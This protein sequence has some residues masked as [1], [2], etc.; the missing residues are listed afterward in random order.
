MTHYFDKKQ[1]SEFKPIK[2][3]ISFQG[4]KITFFSASGI[5]SK[6]ELDTGSALLIRSAIIKNGFSVLDLGCGFGAIGIILAKKYPLCSFTLAD[7]N[8]RAVQISKMNIELHVLKNA[9]AK[10]S[11]FFDCIED[12]FHTILLNPPQTAGKDVC[13][14]LISDSFNHLFSSGLLQI[15]ARKNKGGVSYSSHMKS[16]FGNVAELSHKA[17]FVV[18]VSRKA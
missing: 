2:I 16:V 15:V 6:D 18:Y 8:E 12:N 7:V 1:D 14:K 5:F 10:E 4:E 9:T 17:G 13:F 3:E 11:S